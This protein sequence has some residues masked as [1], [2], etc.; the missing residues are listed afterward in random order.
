M[1]ID[2]GHLLAEGGKLCCGTLSRRQVQ[3]LHARLIDALTRFASDYCQLPILRVYWY[4]AAPDAIPTH[5]QLE[6][7]ELDRVKLRLG[8]LSGGK[9]KGVDSLIV[10]DLMTLARERAIATAFLVG[11]DEDLREGVV[12]AQ[13]FGVSVVVVGIPTTSWGNQA[14]TLI[15]EADEH[16]VLEAGFLAPFF[17]RRE[18]PTAIA[19]ELPADKGAARL[20]GQSF[21]LEWTRLAASEDIRRLLEQAPIIP[22]PLDAQLVL[23]AERVLGSLQTRKKLK[24]DLRAGFWEAIKG[25]EA[26]SG[27]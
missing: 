21:A 25:F 18:E 6:I 4:D 2:A 22:Y 5:D 19:P 27:T 17:S 13:E 9:Q 24:K 26:P 1:F 3:C 15:R 16:R 8:R 14:R 20:A 7:A 23:S 10:R 12:A 11:G